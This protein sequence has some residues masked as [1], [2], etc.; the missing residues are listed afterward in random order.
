MFAIVGDGSRLQAVPAES[1]APAAPT[2]AHAPAR[3]H[4]ESN[5]PANPPSASSALS[6]FQNSP[7]ADELMRRQ[8]TM[9]S[10]LFAL[11]NV[12]K[13]YWRGTSLEVYGSVPALAPDVAHIRAAME[14]WQRQ[15]REGDGVSADS[16]DTTAASTS[17]TCTFTAHS[18]QH[19]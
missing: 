5:E 18:W 9:Q 6:I 8:A 11:E 19:H 7:G 15:A 4:M 17:S 1:V 14:A 16:N 2:E 13:K 12:A 10:A 3:A